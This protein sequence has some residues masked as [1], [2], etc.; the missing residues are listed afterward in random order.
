MSEARNV[1]PLTRQRAFE[2]IKVV[3]RAMLAGEGAL[4]YS[5]L[6]KRLGMS[7]VNGQGLSSYLNL[8][9]TLCAEHDLPNV[10]VMVVSKDSLDRNQPMPSEG[11]FSDGFYA[12]TGLTKADIPAEQDRVRSFDWRSVRSL[13][14]E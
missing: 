5:E 10:S 12:A 13:N 11:S 3:A 4:T 7:K 9:A 1:S 2:T 14:L 8:A 6:A